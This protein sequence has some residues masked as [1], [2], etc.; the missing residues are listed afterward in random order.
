[1]DRARAYRRS[2]FPSRQAQV[3]SGSSTAP[4]RSG[5]DRIALRAHEMDA[6]L[7]ASPVIRAG[8]AAA[9]AALPSAEIAA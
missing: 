1:M 2:A 7:P 8:P 6:G 9:S 5:E 3:S 4:C